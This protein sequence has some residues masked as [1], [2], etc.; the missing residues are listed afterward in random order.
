MR[1][2]WETNITEKVPW[3]IRGKAREYSIIKK[4]TNLVSVSYV[5][6]FI[7]YLLF[8]SLVW[9][10]F[11]FGGKVNFEWRKDSEK[12]IKRNKCCG[13]CQL[14]KLTIHVCVIFLHFFCTNDFKGNLTRCHEDHTC[15]QKSSSACW[16]STELGLA[17]SGV[18]GWFNVSEPGYDAKGLRVVKIN[19]IW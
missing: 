19:N 4:F 13:W 15:E 10:D 14:W 17:N 3:F 11:G 2:H 1:T 9:F 5:A 18:N 16:N 12:K 7:F 8:L 6:A